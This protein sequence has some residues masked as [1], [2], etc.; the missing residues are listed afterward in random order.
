MGNAEHPRAA[1]IWPVPF[2]GL[3]QVT[4]LTEM[5]DMTPPYKWGL[6]ESLLRY[7]PTT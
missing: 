4:G 1:E 5:V 2:P 7:W 3:G 6:R